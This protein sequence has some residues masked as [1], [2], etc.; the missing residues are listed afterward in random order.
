M[1]TPLHLQMAH[2]EGNQGI[3]VLGDLPIRSVTYK[4]LHTVHG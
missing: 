1:L 4:Y 3:V 2:L